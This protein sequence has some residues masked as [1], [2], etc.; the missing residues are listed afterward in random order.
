MEIDYPPQMG[1]NILSVKSDSYAGVSQIFFPS[2]LVHFFVSVFPSLRN[3]EKM[4]WIYDF[5]KKRFFNDH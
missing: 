4:S 2:A 1:K 5:S 3:Y